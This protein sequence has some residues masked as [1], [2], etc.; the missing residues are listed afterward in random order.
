M[1]SARGS[2]LAVAL[3]FM[4]SLSGTVTF[5]QAVHK[6]LGKRR[7]SSLRSHRGKRRSSFT[8]RYAAS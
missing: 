7:G 8:L 1:Y 4:S 2:I 3:L 5:P 6:R